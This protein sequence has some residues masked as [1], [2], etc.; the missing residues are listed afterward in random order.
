MDQVK[1][2]GTFELGNRAVDFSQL[3]RSQDVGPVVRIGESSA[4]PDSITCQLCRIA[5]GQLA[6][7]ACLGQTRGGTSLPLVEVWGVVNVRLTGWR[8]C[9]WSDPSGGRGTRSGCRG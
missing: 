5:L 8:L 4:V 3:I 2:L 1:G 9:C 7:T 6:E